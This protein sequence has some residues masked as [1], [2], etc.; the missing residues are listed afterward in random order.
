M[1]DFFRDSRPSF[2]PF[3]KSCKKIP[4]ITFLIRPGQINM[5]TKIHR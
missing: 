5:C 4:T 3:T 2:F 1:P